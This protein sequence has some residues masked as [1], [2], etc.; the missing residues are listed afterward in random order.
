MLQS[1]RYTN[2]E[3]EMPQRTQWLNV[4]SGKSYFDRVHRPLQCLIVIT[5]L[6]LFYQ[7]GSAVQGV[8]DAQGAA[9]VHVTA[10]VLLIRFF[11]IFGAV[12]S[13]LPMLA[14]V[15]ILI[16]WHLARKDKWDFE[17]RL[18]AGMI[19]EGA[20]WTIPLVVI[21]LALFRNT[22][23]GMLPAAAAADTLPPYTSLLL[24]S[25]GAGVY[26]EL[27]FR[28]IAIVMLNWL[29]VEVFELKLPLAIPLIILATAL[30]FAWYHF[31]G[32]M[33]FSAPL[34]FYYTFLGIYWAGLFAFRGF[35][36]VV[37]CHALYDIV[38]VTM[39]TYRGH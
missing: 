31:A 9:P 3:E 14:V 7:I 38:A 26:E 25:V 13:Y 16:S 36:I 37:W 39:Q 20:L 10:F 32:G 17:P 23:A 19:G 18:Y 24:L 27:L 6:L 21:G 29:L 30:L 15:A 1:P 33:P 22:P 5:P 11:R 8:L 35:G 12:G 2:S 34:F 4:G 28:L